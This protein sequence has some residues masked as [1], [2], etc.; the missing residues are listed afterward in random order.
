MKGWKKIVHANRNKKMP[1][2]AML[3]SE[4]IDLKVKTV[5]K[6][7]EG[8]YRMIRGSVQQEDNTFININILYVCIGTC[9]YNIYNFCI[10]TL[11]THAHIIYAHTHIHTQHRSNKI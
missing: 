5:I 1:S 8:Y 7:E 11:Y 3:I 4:K 9:M 6:D 2:V 10:R